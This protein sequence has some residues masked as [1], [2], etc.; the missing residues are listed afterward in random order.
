[1]ETVPFGG[2]DRCAK[3][4]AGRV[5]IIVTLEVGPRVLY[6]GIDGGPNQLHVNAKDAGIRGGTEYHSFGGHRLWTA[7]EDLVKTYTPDNEPVEHTEDGGWHV[8]K[9]QTDAFGIRKEYRIRPEPAQERFRLVHR[10]HN[11]GSE[12]VTLAPW[13]LTVMA[14]GG[15][16]FIPQHPFVPHSERLLPTRPVVLWGYT[17]MDDPRW[18][19]GSRVIRL[20]QGKAGPQKIGS[21]VQQGAA[22]YLNSGILFLKRFPYDAGANYPD[23]GCNFETFTREDMLEVESL[24]GL[25]TLAPGQFA[26]LAETWYLLPGQTAPAADSECGDWLDSLIDRHPFE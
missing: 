2:W 21:L 25:Q 20:R 10:V 14:A 3:L 16:C 6:L 5:E 9:N 11:L 22:A 18:T 7:P 26:E 12:A 13:C 17:R 19:W 23:F 15:E 8:F 24:G 1:M 4:T